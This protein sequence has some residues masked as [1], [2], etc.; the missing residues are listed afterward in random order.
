MAISTILISSNSSE[1]S[2]GTPSGRVLWFGRIPT[3]V[4]ATTPTIDP[5]VIHD[6]TSLIPTKTPT[7]SSITSMIPPTAPTIHYT[8]SF[9]HTD[10]SDD[11]ILDTPLSPTHEIPLVEP[12]PYGR[13]Y[14]YHPNGPIHMMTARKRVGPLPTHHLAMRHSVDY[15]SS[16]HFT[17]GDSARDS[18]SDSSSETSSDSSSDALSDSLSGHSSSDHS[19]P[20]LPS[21]MRS[22]HQLCASVSS[23]PHSSAVITERASY[24]SFVSPSRKRSRPPTTSVP[25]S[26]PILG[27]LSSV[28][29]DLL[30][31]RKRIRSS[32]SVTDLEASSDVSFESSIPRESSSRVDIDIGDVRVVVETVAREEVEMSARGKVKIRIDR[33]THPVV[34]DDILEPAHEEGAIEVIESIHRD[35]GHRI[36]ATGQQ[37]AIQSERISELERDN[38]RLKGMLDVASQR[39]TQFQRRELR[40]QREMRQIWRLRFYD[41][42]RIVSS[43]SE[44]LGICKSYLLGTMMTM[45]N[46]R[47]GATMTREGINE[48]I[49]H[50]VAEALEARDAARNLE[51]LAE[52]G[53]EQEDKNGDDYE[54]GNGGGN[55]NGN[56]NANRGGE[57]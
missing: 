2:V 28:H 29:A 21:G 14:R 40:V 30:P 6:D 8:S 24:S 56:G 15:S 27:A 36:V 50:Q 53:D 1:E 13:P 25:V 43:S 33:V 44:L 10:S 19:S 55:G 45:P 22:S 48:L 23:I 42:V 9:I 47:S 31:P 26:L 34:L 16:D 11:D 18:P 35:Q 17:S 51:P 54:G 41:R 52:G 5:P 57:E 12:I 49:A 20:A 32:D 39:V 46:T 7:I 37:S 3:T 38:M 4:P